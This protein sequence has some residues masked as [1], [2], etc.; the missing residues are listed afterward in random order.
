METRR[1]FIRKIGID[2]AFTLNFSSVLSQ[3]DSHNTTEDRKAFTILFQGD[4]ITDGNRTR[5]YD[6][7]HIW[8]MVMP[9]LLQAGCGLRILKK[10]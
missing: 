10:I 6:W 9:V 8:D 7:N 1:D 3:S 5:D 2:S 4:S